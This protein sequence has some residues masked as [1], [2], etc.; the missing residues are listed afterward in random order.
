MIPNP[1]ISIC[2]VSSILDS[3]Y[4]ST[5]WWQ[6]KETFYSFTFEGFHFTIIFLRSLLHFFFVFFLTNLLNML[7]F[8]YLLLSFHHLSAKRWF[9][10]G[11]LFNTSNRI[12]ACAFVH[13]LY[14]K[15]NLDT[16]SS[17][18]MSEITKLSNWAD[19]M[20]T[21][22]LYFQPKQPLGIRDFTECSGKGLRSSI[23]KNHKFMLRLLKSL[24]F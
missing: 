24:E 14:L 7:F 15:F 4:K 13:D 3:E 18:S 23:T 10:T 11:Y 6:Y 22:K 9:I 16:T 8:S 17:K 5:L 12:P 19:T 1:Q 2:L 21:K 20:T